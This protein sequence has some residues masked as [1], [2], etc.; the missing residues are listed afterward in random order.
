MIGSKSVDFV[1]GRSAAVRWRTGLFLLILHALPVSALIIGTKPL[2]WIVLAIIFPF[3]GI[4]VGVALH[5][6]FTHHSFQT[7]RGFQFALGLMASIAFGDPICFAGKHRLHHQ[8]SDTRNDVHTPLHGAWQCWIGSLIDCG[9]S[10]DQ[11]RERAQDLWRYPE[12]RWL[13]RY[14]LLPGLTLALIA[15]LIG[16]YTTLAIGFCLMPVILMHQSSAVN[17]FCHRYGTQRFDVGDDS[18]NNALVAILTLGEGWH[19]NHH[20][21]PQCAHAGFYWWEIDMFYW[22]IWVFE[23]LGLI[24]AVKGVPVRAA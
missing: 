17:Y 9:Y 3:G 5:R 12:L 15:F 20:R 2:D 8:Y 6:Y 1:P 22:A 13:H 18:R 11:L 4:G 19:N 10:D 16:G 23:K 21:Y 14:R 24:W 7:S